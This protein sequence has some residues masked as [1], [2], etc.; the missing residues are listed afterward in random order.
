MGHKPTVRELLDQK[1]A[2]IER[3]RADL[4]RRLA[5]SPKPVQDEYA[6]CIGEIARLTS[7][8]G[9]KIEEK[10]LYPA[11]GVGRI[12]TGNEIAWLHDLLSHP[13]NGWEVSL[14]KPL[15]SA[16]DDDTKLSFRFDPY[17][18]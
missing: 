1:R 12:L 2:M 3:N 11:R 10:V 17:E 18:D 14:S 8:P 6:R 9:A 7:A 15:G 16:S 5:E 13:A 4:A